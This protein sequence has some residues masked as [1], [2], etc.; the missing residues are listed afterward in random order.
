MYS[1]GRRTKRWPLC[2]FFNF[3]DVVAINSAVIY[4]AVKQDGGM[5]RKDFIKQLALQ[6]MRDALNMRNQAKNL[7]RDLQVLIQ[8]HAGTSS[9]EDMYKHSSTSMRG[10]LISKII[11]LSTC[12]SRAL[13]T[14][15]DSSLR[16]GPEMCVTAG[17]DGLGGEGNAGLGE[18]EVPDSVSVYGEECMSIQMVRRWRSWFLVGRQNV[19]DDE[20]SGSPVTATDNAAVAAVRNVVEADRRVTIDE[21]MIRLPPGIEI[22]HSSIGTIMSDV[23]NFLEVCTR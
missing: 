15:E 11:I 21:I 7:S 4:K 16:C 5:A 6:L 23:L 8:K 18:T 19:H 9:L 14:L 22:R 10:H 3:L 2:L 12:S 17:T 1:V 13:S 20:R